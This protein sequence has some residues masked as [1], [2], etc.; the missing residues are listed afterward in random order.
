[1]VSLPIFIGIAKGNDGLL[2]PSGLHIRRD[3]NVE[4]C[5]EKKF[6]RH[7]RCHE[8]AWILLFAG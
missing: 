3:R 7:N 6:R 2:G 1:M 4:A 8:L 5:R